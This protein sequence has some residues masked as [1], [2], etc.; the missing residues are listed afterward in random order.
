V[1]RATGG[2]ISIHPNVF[3]KVLEP[4]PIKQWQVQQTTDGID[5][6]LVRGNEPVDASAVAASIGR[7]LA[8]A[9][10]AQIQVRPQLVDKVVQTALGKAPLVMRA[11]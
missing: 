2:T 3:H 4:L 11:R 10:A 9:G 5:V 1:P 8:A 6:R 7:E